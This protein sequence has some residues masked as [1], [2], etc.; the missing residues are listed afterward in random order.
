[1]TA[2]SGPIQLSTRRP[3]GRCPQCRYP[4]DPG[5]CPE[6]G[7]QVGAAELLPFTDPSKRR[8]WKRGLVAMLV[9]AAGTSCWFISERGL[10]LLPYLP[11]RV[12]L[13][14]AT[15]AHS[16]VGEELLRRFESGQLSSQDAGRFLDQILQLTLVKLRSPRPAE[17]PI[18][19]QGVV[20]CDLQKYISPHMELPKLYD[21]EDAW[22]ATIDDVTV[23]EG[24]HEWEKGKFWTYYEMPTLG[25]GEHRIE[26]RQMVTIKP[27]ASLGYGALAYLPHASSVK[28]SLQ[29]VIEDRALGEYVR[30]VWSTDLAC[31]ARS[32]VTLGIWRDD[33]SGAARCRISDHRGNAKLAS[34]VW[35]RQQPDAAYVMQEEQH[36]SSNVDGAVTT[37]VDLKG[38][39]ATDS[40]T[41]CD[42]CLLPSPAA[43]FEAGFDDYFAGI[44]EWSDVPVGD[45][46]G[47]SRVFSP[48]SIRHW[49]GESE[50][51]AVPEQP[52]NVDRPPIRSPDRANGEGN[53]Q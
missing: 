27:G 17:L 3:S 13:L 37:R 15:N 52:Q 16:P 28:A 38:I 5:C 43:A 49:R 2:E 39:Q 6:C 45:S 31:D 22:L 46:A 9:L 32:K 36:V 19:L 10:A 44:I 42:I 48:T 8:R 26:L 51:H 11:A 18:V 24:T 4:L 30:P 25:V 40:V 33:H 12:L 23:T 50:P 29:V 1:M 20:F 47:A 34:T 7:L 41:Y 21:D 35:V 14:F 53:E